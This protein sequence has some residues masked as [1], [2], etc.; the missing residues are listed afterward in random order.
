MTD[1][2]I[3]IGV[4]VLLRLLSTRKIPKGYVKALLKLRDSLNLAFP[5]EL[6]DQPAANIKIVN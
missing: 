2:F 6:V 3:D 4:T 5:P 1:F